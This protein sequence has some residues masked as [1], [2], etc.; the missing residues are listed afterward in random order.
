MGVIGRAWDLARAKSNEWIHGK[1]K[2]NAGARADE[3]AQQMQ[4]DTAQFTT[5]AAEAIA[6]LEGVKDQKKAADAEVTKWHNAAKQFLSTGNETAAKQA[7]DRENS[8][9]QLSAKLQAQIDQQQARIDTYKEKA[10]NLQSEARDAQNTAAAIQAREKV[11][12]AEEKI[13]SADPSA[14]LNKLKQAEADVTQR[15]RTQD[16]VNDMDGSNLEAQANK[17]QREQANNDSLAALR[18][19]MGQKPAAPPAAPSTPVTVPANGQVDGF[20]IAK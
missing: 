9:K 20:N 12:G 2:Q 19:E 17:L 4:K 13:K 3:A 10:Q 16:A 11:V 1:E 6:T 14:S 5:G 8:A 7:L 18:A 15:E